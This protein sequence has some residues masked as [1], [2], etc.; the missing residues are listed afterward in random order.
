MISL[1]IYFTCLDFLEWGV[2]YEQAKLKF[3]HLSA[4]SKGYLL[5]LKNENYIKNIFDYY[6]FRL[7]D[8]Y[9]SPENYLKNIN[10][11]H[12]W[13]KYE[14]DIDRFFNIIYFFILFIILIILTN[15]RNIIFKDIIIKISSSI[16]FIFLFSISILTWIYLLPQ[17]RYGGYG[18]VFV[19]LCFISL[20]LVS[21]IKHIRVI[22]IYVLIFISIF[23]FEFRNIE[24]IITNYDQFK[25][26]LTV[27]FYNYPNL[28]ND[29]LVIN[30]KFQV[31][32]NQKKF[33]DE[34]DLGKPLY[35]F[36]TKGLCGSILRT[37]CLNRTYKYNNY[38]YVI[39][40]K[41]QCAKLIDKYLWY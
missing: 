13:W 32:V 4:Q 9:V 16:L 23:Y 28:N 7:N 10:W 39:A 18:I 29:N 20:V 3:Y 21:S 1:A 14:Y 41:E 31:S 24:R 26:K 6:N 33:T 37:E 30:D 36:D 22:P 11:I 5:W 35:C 19:F 38:I 12:Y 2:G 25:N 40:N 15:L 27:N 34:N 8:N 17:T